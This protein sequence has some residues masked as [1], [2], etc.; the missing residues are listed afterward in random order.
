[1]AERGRGWS[2]FRRLARAVGVADEATAD[3]APPPAPATPALDQVHDQA[4]PGA[5]AVAQ[6]TPVEPADVE[7]T[8]T[9]TPAEEVPAEPA[10]SAE[11]A[12]PQPPRWTLAEAEERH[13]AHPR[14][15][16]I[17]N[18][19]TRGSLRIGD[20]VALLFYAADPTAAGADAERMWVEVLERVQGAYLGR[21]LNRPVVV[22][23]LS[24]GDELAFGPEHVIRVED[25]RWAPFEREVAFVNARLLVDDD[26]TPG[27]VL[28]DPQD[29]GEPLEAGGP[30]A[31]GWQL[32]VGDETQTELDDP[33]ALQTP[34][35]NWL[36][37]RYP[38]FGDLVFSGARDGEWHLDPAT[39]TFVP[40]DAPTP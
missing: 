22:G 28:H 4:E 6:P 35:L 5:E 33:A 29:A 21:L 24:L 10:E 39:G 27:F 20:R 3:A 7:P 17:P 30:A 12:E 36:M 26:L 19:E 38:A 23:G 31:S 25:A 14:S 2:R 32:L 1:M 16:F 8:E 40:E 15:F 18:A 13:R 34:A 9:A 11:P 37:E